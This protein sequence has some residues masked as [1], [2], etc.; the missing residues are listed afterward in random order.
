MINLA[1]STTC[2]GCTACYN[3]CSQHAIKM[4]EDIEGFL[5]PHIEKDLCIECGKCIQVCPVISP[6]Y[7]NSEPVCFA[8]YAESAVREKSSSG[9]I[10]T[11]LANSYLNE[12]GWVCGAAYDSTFNVKHILVNQKDDLEKL[13]GSKY[14]QSD[15]TNIFRSVKKLLDQDKKVL[16]SGLPCQVAGLK[17]YLGKE[18]DALLTIDLFCHGVPSPK[19][20]RKYLN[21]I[22][23][24]KIVKIDFRNKEHYGWSSS[25]TI[26]FEDGTQYKNSHR[27][28]Y[29]YKAFLP[30]MSVRNSCSRCKFSHTP[31]QGDISI[32]DYW[33]VEKY[34]PAL[35]DGKGVSAILVNNEKGLL[36]W[37][38]IEY[39]LEKVVP[40]NFEDIAVGNPTLKQPFHSHPGRKHF[41]SALDIL[42]FD[43][44]V[45]NSLTHHYDVGIVG[46]WY[47]INYGSI[48]TY[49]AL[50]ETIH[51][52]GY[53][54]IFLSKPN[55]LWNEKFNNP[56]TIA[57][58]FIKPRCNVSN[59]RSNDKDWIQ[60]ND[61]CDT[62]ILGA[63]V[64]WNYE[65]C[66]KDAGQYFFLDFVNNDKKKIAYSSSFASGYNAPE[67]ERRKSQYYLK[68]FDYVAVRE[69]EGIDI[70]REKFDVTAIQVLDPVFL[71]PESFYREIINS[72]GIA[73]GERYVATYILGVNEQKRSFIMQLSEHLGVSNRNFVDPNAPEKGARLLNL[74]I[75]PDASVEKWL[76]YIA[77]SEFFVGDSFH[78]L[79][80]ALI[81]RKPFVCFVNRTEPSKVRF[82]SL[83]KLCGLEDRLIYT[84]ED[85]TNKMSAILEPIDY[86]SVYEKL[87]K[88]IEFSRDWLKKALDTPKSTIYNEMD[89]LDEQ[90]REIMEL[91]Q[92]FLRLENEMNDF[93]RTIDE[94]VQIKH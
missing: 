92:K 18:Y 91:E 32:G 34:L 15:M 35:N 31:R 76:Y 37:R 54:P 23:P 74:P 6:E 21:E 33:G 87:N 40:A 42:P 89:I 28:D 85:Y 36:Q 67:Q 16:F 5:S 25:S 22:S 27:E 2:T 77:N 47:G 90:F 71:L 8:G 61:H 70:C 44:L 69:Q 80:F 3:T 72:A 68:R 82:I 55:K 24:K 64:I 60:M 94:D 7:N 79:C 58:K 84:D 52:L 9:G 30:C 38:K 17:K 29:F 56:D 65:I 63:D 12:G 59:L 73:D 41:F 66:G 62:F 48:L 1:S 39:Q 50:Y 51:S 14:V 81:F 46:L 45:K 53:D 83:L 13:R 26:T 57:H 75:V 19:V 88:N 11:V 86:D 49:Y 43:Q 4:E 20:Y 93:K 78:G 10:F